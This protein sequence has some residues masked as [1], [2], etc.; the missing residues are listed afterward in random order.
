MFSNVPKIATGAH[1][2]EDSPVL[3]TVGAPSA[4]VLGKEHGGSRDDGH[5]EGS[6]S[7]ND[8][9][10]TWLEE[11][12][13]QHRRDINTTLEIRHTEIV[14]EVTRRLQCC[15]LAPPPEN[16]ET[17]LLSSV[18]ESRG[19]TQ[20]RLPAPNMQTH[21]LERSAD[22]SRRHPMVERVPGQDA[23]SESISLAVEMVPSSPSAK[24]PK[25]MHAAQIAE[26]F[27]MRI[28]ATGSQRSA[29]DMDELIGRMTTEFENPPVVASKSGLVRLGSRREVVF[30]MVMAIVIMCNAL[31]VIVE[32]QYNSFDVASDTLSLPH[33][34]SAEA[35]WR[36]GRSF[37]EVMELVF[38]F[39]F[40]AEVFIMIA[41][42]GT[43][44][45]RS[46]WH[47]FDIGICISWTIDLFHSS[48]NDLSQPLMRTVK[49]VRLLRLMR[50]VRVL[51]ILDALSLLLKTMIKSFGVLFWSVLLIFLVTIMV[52]LLVGFVLDDYIGDTANPLE[53]RIQVYRAWGSPSRAVA[54][55]FEVTLGNWGPPCRL[56]QNE[57]N[58]AWVLFFISYKLIVGFAVV[59]VITS[60]FVQQTFKLV[61]HD[62]DVLL[63]EKEEA[64]VANVR[65]LTRL[66]EHID[67]SGDGLISRH[68][69]D[70]CFSNEKIVSWFKAI[71]IDVGEISQLFNVM[72]SGDGVVDYQEFVKFVKCIKSGARM[73]DMVDL[74]MSTAR[75]EGALADLLRKIEA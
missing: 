71:D 18:S 33:Q 8:S 1:D 4:V 40:I 53:S 17:P 72:Q 46:P 38:G 43:R 39:V 21:S 68:E 37:F 41:F 6:G 22:V 20:R 34:Q 25:V 74:S 2:D 54:T 60:V 69:F 28:S 66:F 35:R 61:A 56:L 16:F 63:R 10:R 67:T 45:F 49:L 23:M 64:A 36:W 47:Y 44:Y 3:R 29:S 31:V 14:R 55:M 9:T 73:L 5:Y 42:Q 52:A 59:Q 75:I 70:T 26:T 11:V 62:E 48:S 65:H 50:L 32:R 58:E 57:V 27:T 51:T 13:L 30:E 15:D 12:F 7:F 19:R 24:L